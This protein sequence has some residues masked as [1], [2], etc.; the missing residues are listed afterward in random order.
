MKELTE[1]HKDNKI[2]IEQRK[3]KGHILWEFNLKTKELKPASFRKT[4]VLVKS[5]I[6][7]ESSAQHNYKVVVNENCIYFQALNR[8]NALKKLT[9]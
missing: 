8:K 6:P 3:V 7:A 5:L 1:E 9:S 2:E 4:D